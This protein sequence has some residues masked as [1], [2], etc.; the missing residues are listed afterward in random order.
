MP[1]LSRKKGYPEV[2]E[3]SLATQ[4]LFGKNFGIIFVDCKWM[5]ETDYYVC[6]RCQITLEREFMP[7][8][9]RCGQHL[10]WRNYKKATIVY[11]GTMK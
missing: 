8:F 3:E 5:G 7:F 1:G 11:P 10:D 4:G 6:P 9:D 2:L